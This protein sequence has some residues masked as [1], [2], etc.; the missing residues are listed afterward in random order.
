MLQPPATSAL[1]LANILL[2]ILF[3]KLKER[4]LQNTIKNAVDVVTVYLDPYR[5]FR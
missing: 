4:I 5:T 2:S 1:S 3:P